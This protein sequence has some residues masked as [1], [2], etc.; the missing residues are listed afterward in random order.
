[1]EVPNMNIHKRRSGSIPGKEKCAK[2]WVDS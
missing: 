2:N 1:M